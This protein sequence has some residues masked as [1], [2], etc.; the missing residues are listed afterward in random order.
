MHDI[1]TLAANIRL[2]LMD[3][4]GVMTDGKLYN[5]PGP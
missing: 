3:C 5:V 4:D 1:Q 2:L